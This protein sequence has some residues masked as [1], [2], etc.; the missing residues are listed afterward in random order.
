MEE[1]QPETEEQRSKRLRRESRRHLRV[2]FK[3]DDA[4][5]D[6]RL[7]THDPDEEISREDVTMRDVDDVGG[8]GRMLKKHLDQMM[9]DDDEQSPELV[10]REFH[11][12]SGKF[13]W[14]SYLTSRASNK[15]QKSTLAS[16]ANMSVL[17]T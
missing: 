17:I 12:P 2:S 14:L 8:E 11:T 10:L 15:T 13:R 9:D 5:V 7:F 3:P 4:L 6:V 16:L 1:K